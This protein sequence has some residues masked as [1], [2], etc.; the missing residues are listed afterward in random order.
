MNSPCKG[1]DG[2]WCPLSLSFPLLFRFPTAI[3]ISIP[4]HSLPRV[5][6]LVGVRIVIP[7]PNSIRNIIP[8]FIQGSDYHSR[9][10]LRLESSFR[11]SCQ[12]RD[13]S[14]ISVPDSVHSCLQPSLPVPLGV[15]GSIQFQYN[16]FLTRHWIFVYYFFSKLLRPAR[17]RVLNHWGVAMRARAAGWFL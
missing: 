12:V 9:S 5:P 2:F 11:F 17:L 3:H 6:I 14:T 13:P 10:R 7:I 16:I 8:V 1:W 15:E 4:I